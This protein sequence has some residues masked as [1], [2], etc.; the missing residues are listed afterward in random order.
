MLIPIF[1]VGCRVSV[2]W[3]NGGGLSFKGWTLALEMADRIVYNM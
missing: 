1:E 2:E 3:T